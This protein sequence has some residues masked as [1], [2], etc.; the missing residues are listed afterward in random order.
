[1]DRVFGFPE[2]KSR[3][4]TRVLSFMASSSEN[5]TVNMD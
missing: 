4:V 5:D 1:V 3:R 2:R